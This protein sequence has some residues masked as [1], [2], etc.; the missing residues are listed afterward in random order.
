[1]KLHL[2]LL[3]RKALVAA[4]FAC[5]MVFTTSSASVEPYYKLDDDWY[6]ANELTG[7]HSNKEISVYDVGL[8]NFAF[9]GG[10][11]HGTVTSLTNFNINA[12]ESVM[13][14][15]KSRGDLSTGSITAKEF[16]ILDNFGNITG[17]KLV[18]SREGSVS[19]MADSINYTPPAGAAGGG[20]DIMEV[21]AAID[22]SLRGDNISNVNVTGH[23]VVISGNSIETTPARSADNINVT[24]INADEISAFV[25]ECESVENITV[26]AQLKN[27]TTTPMMYPTA[28]FFAKSGKN[29][30]VTN[31]SLLLDYDEAKSTFEN[32]TRVGTDG[33]V[34]I[35]KD[36]TVTGTLE[37]ENVYITQLLMGTEGKVFD[38]VTGHIKKG[39]YLTFF[40]G[41]NKSGEVD[42]A[43]LSFGKEYKISEIANFFV[44]SGEIGGEY[45]SHNENFKYLLH[46]TGTL[47]L[48]DNKLIYISGNVLKGEGAAALYFSPSTQSVSDQQ[49]PADKLVISNNEQVE[50][51]LNIADSGEKLPYAIK[52]EGGVVE[53]NTTD[54]A[55][56]Y[57][58]FYQPVSLTGEVLLNS[59]DGIG[60]I[61]FSGEFI[62]SYLTQQSG[63][64]E[65]DLKKSDNRDNRISARQSMINGNVTQYSGTLTLAKSAILDISGDFSLM[66]GA[67]VKLGPFGMNEV[68]ENKEQSCTSYS[69]LKTTNLELDAEGIINFE[70]NEY[71]NIEQPI[72]KIA[73]S[74]NLQS[75]S[76][77]FKL[78]GKALEQEQ[79]VALLSTMNLC[80]PGYET[81]SNS[82][83]GNI[84]VWKL[85]DGSGKVKLCDINDLWRFAGLNK[86][87]GDESKT[88][89]V[90]IGDTLYAYQPNPVWA[91]SMPESGSSA[92]TWRGDSFQF[93]D[94]DK[95]NVMLGKTG[96]GKLADCLSCWLYA[97]ANLIQYWQDRYAPLY[98]GED[99][100]VTNKETPNIQ[101]AEDVFKRMWGSARGVAESGRADEALGWWFSVSLFKRPLN[102][103]WFRCGSKPG[104][105]S[106]FGLSSDSS[107]VK[108]WDT[109]DIYTYISDKLTKEDVPVILRYPGHVITCW[110]VDLIDEDEGLI[111]FYV[112][113]SDGE[114]IDKDGARLQKKDKAT[115]DKYT[116]L[117][118]K[119][120]K[121]RRELLIVSENSDIVRNKPIEDLIS[122]DTSQSMDGMLKTLASPD[123]PMYW[124]GKGTEW[125][126]RSGVKDGS[127][128]HLA[129]PGDGWKKKVGN[130]IWAHA[131]FIEEAGNSGCVYD[132]LVAGSTTFVFTDEVDGKKLGAYSRQVNL[133]GDLTVKNV[134]VE[135]TDYV[136]GGQ[137]RLSATGTL[138]VAD[139]GKLS[140]GSGVEILNTGIIVNG[141]ELNSYVEGKKTIKN[142]PITL[143]SG[144][145]LWF[146]GFNVGREQSAESLDLKNGYHSTLSGSSLDSCYVSS[147]GSGRLGSFVDFGGSEIDY[148]ELKN[149]SNEILDGQVYA[150]AG[151]A[152]GAYDKYDCVYEWTHADINAS[153]DDIKTSPARISDSALR[154]TAGDSK[155]L[156][157]GSHRALLQG[158]QADISISE[159]DGAT[160]EAEGVELSTIADEEV[161]FAENAVVSTPQLTV[162][163]GSSLMNDGRIGADEMTSMLLVQNN[164]LLS[165]SGRFARTRVQAGGSLMVGSSPGAPVYEGLEMAAG[166]ILT[167]CVDGSE[168]ATAEKNGWG[169]GTHSLLTVTGSLTIASGTTVQVG[170]SLDFL[171]STELGATQTLT[172]IQLSGSANDSLLGALEDGTEFLWAD[173]DALAS[174]SE[175][176]AGV[177]DVSWSAGDGGTVQ[178]SF[179][180]SS[181]VEG[182]LLWSAG[183][184]GVWDAE[185]QNWQDSSGCNAVF[186]A[187]KSVVFYDGGTVQLVGELAPETVLVS[188]V[189]DLVFTGA[190]GLTGEAYL[191]KEGSGELR[192]GTANS[193][194]G[195]TMVYGGRLVAEHSM[196]L[197]EGGVN[198]VHGELVIAADDVE[199]LLVSAG[200]NR[201]TVE[202]GHTVVLGDTILNDGTLTL[203]GTLDVSSLVGEIDASESGRLDINGNVGDNG[204]A[205]ST[206]ISVAVVDGGSIV[207]DG[208]EILAHGMVLTLGADGIASNGGGTNYA[209][210]LVTGSH[211][212]SA[213]AVHEA[214]KGALRQITLNDGVLNAD[215]SVKVAATGGEINLSDGTLSG[216]ISGTALNVSG[217]SLSAQLSG[218]NTLTASDWTMQQSIANTGKLTLT[219]TLD[220][221]ALQKQVTGVEVRVDENGNADGQSGFLRS[222]D[223]TVTV[224]GGTVDSSGATVSYGGQTLSM[225]G[226]TGSGLG[227]VQLG[228]YLLTGN[229]T[230]TVSRIQAKAGSALQKIDMQGGT[231][232][233]D[234]S[235]DALV[236]T[237]GQVNLS[238]GTLGGSLG[239]SAAVEVSGTATITGTNSYSGGTS[240]SNA[241][242][243]ITDAAALGTG[244]ITT[245]GTSSL[246]VEGVTLKLGS[247]IANSGNLSLSGSYDAS[248]LAK[249]VDAVTYVDAT[250]METAAGSGFTHEGDFTVTIAE[251]T[252]N[253]SAAKVTY[254]GAV[255]SMDGGVGSGAGTT[256]F[257]TYRIL[258]GHEVSVSAV[259]AA[260]KDAL[261]QITQGGGVLNADASVQVEA[262]GGEINLSEG[263]LSGSISGTSL[264]VSGGELTAQLSGSNTLTASDWTMQQSIANTGKLTL[265]GTLDASSLQKQLTGEDVRVDENGNAGGQSGFLRTGDF[266]VTV[267]G[268]TVDSTGATV[269]YGG[270]TLSMNG[271]TGSGLGEVQL[272][273][274]LLT[275]NDTATVSRIQAKAGS[276]LQKIDMQ[277]GTLNVDASTDALVATA[278]QVNLSAGTLGGS[279]GGSAAVE[280]SGTATITGTNSYSGGTSLSNAQL[281]ITDAAAL[282]T[283]SITTSGTSSL[284]VEGVTLKLGSVIANSGNL[285]LS[286]SYDASA[287]DRVSGADTYLD[288]QGNVTA[289]GSGFTHVGDF[290]V[291][292]AEGT[293][294]STAARVMYMGTELSMEGGVGRGTSLTDF[295]IYRILDSHEVS[296]SAVKAASKD[297]L[298]QITQGGGVLNADTSVQVEATGGEINLSAGTLSGT[299]SGTALNVSGGALTAQLSG[300]NTLTASD[301][302]IQQSIANSGNLTLTG[303]LDASALQKQLTGVDVRVDEN[304]NAGGQ[305]GFLRTGDFTVT[306]AGGTVDST[307]AT[308]SYGGQTLSMNGG[309]GSGLGEVQLGTYLLTGNDTAT[310]SRIQAK[311]GSALQKIDMQG[312]TLNVDAS[313]D[314]LVATAGQVNLSAGTLGGSLG[315]SAAV[316]VSGTATITGTN[317]YSGGTSLSN[318][319][320]TITDA[321]A[322]GTGSITTSGTS[323][324]IIENVALKL[325]SAI[326]NEGSLSLR[327][328]IDASNLELERLG[329]GRLSLEGREVSL[330]ESGF[331]RA[332]AYHVALVKGGSIVNDGVVVLHDEYLTRARL[333]LG[334]DGVARA[335]GGVDYRQY[336][337]T[338][339][340]EVKVSDIAAVS[341]QNQATLDGVSMDNGTLT[342]DQSMSVMSGG[343]NIHI[344]D[345]AVLSGSIS[346]TAV[347]T[348]AGD[349]TGDITASLAGD[350]TLVVN[351][352]HITVSGANSYTGGTTVNGGTLQAGH[353]AAFGAGEVTVNDATL[354]LNNFTIANKVLLNGKSTLE[355]AS[356]ASNLV[357]GKGASVNIRGGY[358]LGSGETLDVAASGAVYTGALTLGGGILDLDGK[359]TVEGDVTFESGKQTTLDLSGWT[360][361]DDGEVLA[362]FGGSCSGYTEDCLKLSGI[363]GFWNLEFDPLS[364]TLTLAAVRDASLLNL[365]RNQT[366]VYNTI[367]NYGTPTGL[368]GELAKEMMAS[369]DEAQIKQ[370]LDEMGGAEY[371]TLMSG[372]QAAASGHMRRLRGE[373]GSGHQLAGTKTRAYIEAYNHR[374]ELDGDASG[375]G[376]ELSESGGQFALEFIGEGHTSGG[377][378]VAA[379]RSKLQPDGGLTQKSDNTYVDAFVLHR[380]GSYTGKFSLGVG[381]HKY[382]LERRVAGN[383][384]EADTDGSSVNFMHESAWAVSLAES[385]S[386]Q[387]FGAV[388]SS[389]NKLGAFHEKGADTASLQVESQDAWVTT[390]SV[391]ARYLYSFDAVNS[392]PAAT[393]SVQGGLEVDFGDTESEVEMNFEGAR[394][395]SFRQS[396]AERDTFGYNMGASLHLPVSTKAAIYASGD[397]VLRGN[398]YEVNAN[399]G[400]QMAF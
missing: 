133:S 284:V 201:L 167:F 136:F 224:A 117:F 352:G 101:K 56:S 273:T 86:L 132:N 24:L 272:G 177:R 220:A 287:L 361:A 366:A 263:T 204:F 278:G 398:S 380:D 155:N 318:A 95:V 386:V 17:V 286:G 205:S 267:A 268:G 305:S 265:T 28:S 154:I 27:G 340:D 35:G 322:L 296:A 283:G 260:S 345:D 170:C 3:L 59:K 227:E 319:Q 63:E 13:L 293:V 76:K 113:D 349:Y 285:S 288:V 79:A 100:L 334:N 364:G 57:I 7:S 249:V 359:L 325:G 188:T 186:V 394:G 162:T 157:I 140:L 300:S 326:A 179:T 298:Q 253:S 262:M 40:N 315:G 43:L 10:T 294:D 209:E 83:S 236:A 131:Y 65:E 354:D 37:L 62:D 22:A 282:G 107:D 331:A 178:L 250:G 32:I 211:E 302:A 245:S 29:I 212:V 108:G 375:R 388:E 9:S 231:L 55:S 259:K 150:A 85:T 369:R 363:D 230:A 183:A 371:A 130:D 264:N 92:K 163:Q 257:S 98:Q 321:A 348:A 355:H 109:I 50:F 356:G 96:G 69:T 203:K 171:N 190:G 33:A 164:A 237:A 45:P 339:A 102:S 8:N 376:Y 400:L 44:G 208:V 266:T 5:A 243:T 169:S 160:V 317:S 301:W 342:V 389:F 129:E 152:E 34:F 189:E 385:H 68:N 275:G 193:H 104:W 46:S 60:E 368:L 121:E 66:K 42:C 377:F 239:G 210:Y 323:S 64:T 327:G 295:R 336:F 240:L 124:S 304:G 39:E 52:S 330:S 399:V 119:Y 247:V 353:R 235:T 397:A 233:V 111:A 222:G 116:T 146:A 214:S 312:G 346:Q 365:N 173:G 199:L 276:A 4:C 12:Q 299:I 392:A 351:G 118:A 333:E 200:E 187:G 149:L 128:V 378:A 196:A 244:S 213:S 172:L 78:S 72:V 328:C 1:M 255:L 215:A 61:L 71:T 347:T 290:T 125:K 58:Q 185:T 242:L 309:T 343:G 279:L 246:V 51:S 395:H 297:A 88:E 144:G 11:I 180:V 166:S 192:I 391:G 217:G 219:G 77:N 36:V 15:A 73:Q 223:F 316:E 23:N 202:N 161:Y 123:V 25:A 134:R 194:T 153:A 139:G 303:T 271:G 248:A 145:T 306:V 358:T 332:A 393:L 122:I 175:V 229:D 87:Y 158:S 374:S 311:A 252:V 341:S 251:G 379:G 261:Q 313:T 241:Q 20:A 232:N 344:T 54:S 94:T 6:D 207:D 80:I 292:I 335:G 141:G 280:V 26:E 381:V 370:M 137:G 70:L 30:H 48:E 274:Y 256:D 114:T 16:V 337:L 115:T 93:I 338:G 82:K 238:A 106:V 110:G 147:D 270:Q 362:E 195:G 310:V 18:E 197:G 308:V 289:D 198:L 105:W 142:G 156:T 21:K 165:G 176:G 49:A 81:R 99:P 181:A 159:T 75:D 314:A 148:K 350:T 281:T 225:N 184:N 206:E 367:L 47:T 390:L 218:S 53:L 373:M 228:T 234:A 357:L 324:L 74:L 135:E 269:S 277:G 329:E 120:D 97:S 216:T 182:A 31:A 103:V 126:A 14:D 19:L 307:G 372:Q 320:L 2:P 396:G 38:S 168:A 91:A 387:V 67:V 151:V 383:P 138:Q 360:G 90:W 221:S 382:D 41:N 127:L 174:L 89:L 112:T 291:T 191:Q 84:R 226:G 143:L 384:V 254:Q 258:D